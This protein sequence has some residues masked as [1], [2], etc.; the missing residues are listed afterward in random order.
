MNLHSNSLEITLHLPWKPLCDVLHVHGTLIHLYALN[1]I[2][3]EGNDQFVF[4]NETWKNEVLIRFSIAPNINNF[5]KIV[6][7]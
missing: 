1:V 7:V 2:K 5:F 3:I 6:D 4:L